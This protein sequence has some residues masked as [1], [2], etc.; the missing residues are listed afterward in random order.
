MF[1]VADTGA[2][3]CERRV[4]KRRCA[5]LDRVQV[6]RLARRFVGDVRWINMMHVI[7]GVARE[8]AAGRFAN[9]FA[10]GR[11]EF[12]SLGAAGGAMRAV[13]LGID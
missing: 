13:R 10:A 3:E 7:A 8:V 1:R 4:R 6:S 5:G 2:G 11:G 12:L 9:A